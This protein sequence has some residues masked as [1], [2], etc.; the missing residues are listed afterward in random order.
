M[1]RVAA[2]DLAVPV[3]AVLG[4]HDHHADRPQDVVASSL[5]PWW[6]WQEPRGSAEDMRAGAG[7]TSENPR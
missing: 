5:R 3:V 4:N 7:A 2:V 1:I 6:E